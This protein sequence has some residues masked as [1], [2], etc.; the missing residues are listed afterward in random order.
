MQMENRLLQPI[1][2]YEYFGSSFRQE[3][4]K[5][6]SIPAQ[7]LNMGNF[8]QVRDFVAADLLLRNGKRAGV[9]AD[10]KMANVQVHLLCM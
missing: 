7:E 3:A 1:D 8:R 2:F 4:I 6:H 9:L 10:V 5:R